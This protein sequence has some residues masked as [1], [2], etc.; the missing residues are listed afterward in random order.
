MASSA[1]LVCLPSKPME[2]LFP[3]NMNEK[4]LHK[5]IC[6]SFSGIESRYN[7]GCTE[8]A[9]YLFYGLYGQNPVTLEHSLDE[10]PEEMLD[11]N[12]LCYSWDFG[13]N[14]SLYYDFQNVFI[15]WFYRCYPADQG[16]LC[17][18][19]LQPTQLHLPAA[20]CLT[21]EEP[22]SVL[23]DRSRGEQDLLLLLYCLSLI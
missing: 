1:L 9:K 5:K 7:V 11:G 2:T 20:L 14:L 18:S 22:A 10:F 21:L 23:H 3:P 12:L 19:V 8:L 15:L 4:E 13:F 6:F 17:S 16:W